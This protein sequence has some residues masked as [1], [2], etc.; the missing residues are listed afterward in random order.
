MFI[1]LYIRNESL[2]PIG[3]KINCN[4]FTNW[5]NCK[6]NGINVENIIVFGV[7]VYTAWRATKI[8]M[9]YRVKK[10]MSRYVTENTLYLKLHFN[11]FYVSLVYIVIVWYN[12]KLYRIQV[13]FWRNRSR[14][15]VF[16]FRNLRSCLGQRNFRTTIFRFRRPAFFRQLRRSAWCL[17]RH[18]IERTPAYNVSIAISFILA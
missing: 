14:S 7:V 10:E 11:N 15:Y 16:K 5:E 9:T 6:I 12:Y 17:F 8:N 1:S 2:W 4:C 3:N 18:F 13:L